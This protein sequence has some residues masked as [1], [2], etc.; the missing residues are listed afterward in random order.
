LSRERDA[1]MDWE[2]RKDRQFIVMRDSPQKI[3]EAGY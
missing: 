1:M 2:R 3:M